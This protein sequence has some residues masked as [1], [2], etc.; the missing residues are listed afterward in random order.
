MWAWVITT[1]ST[2]LG[3]IPAAF[4]L[5]CSLPVVGPNRC[6]LP[7]PVDQLVA[8]VH[9]QSVLLEDSVVGRQE[10]LGQLPVG[11][12]RGESNVVLVGIA[13]RQRAVR[14]DG[15]LEIADLEA[16]EG[17]SLGR[18]CAAEPIE[19]R[20]KVPDPIPPSCKVFSPEGSTMP[21]MTYPAPSVS[22]LPLPANWIAVP[23]TIIKI[24]CWRW[25]KRTHV[26]L[27]DSLTV[28]FVSDI[29]WP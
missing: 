13:E 1:A 24:N 8:G 20:S 6:R 28:K 27:I 4:R 23:P 21:S 11:L 19:V 7:S 16:V 26:K 9:N 12:L 29:R 2:S 17:R 10:I 14:R 18:Y 5:D 3:S 15:R 25:G 22:V